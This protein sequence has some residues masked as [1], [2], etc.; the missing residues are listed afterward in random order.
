MLDLFPDLR[1]RSQQ[2]LVAGK[3]LALAD[4]LPGRGGA[5]GGGG[6][7]GGVDTER[8]GP[9]EPEE[10]EASSGRGSLSRAQRRKQKKQQQRAG[11]PPP[12][13]PPR[14][15]VSAASA[16]SGVVGGGG[17]GGGSGPK[18]AEVSAPYNVQ[19]VSHVD[20]N[21]LWTGN[22]EE[23]FEVARSAAVAVACRALVDTSARLA[24][25]FST[26]A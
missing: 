20:S 13:T 6:G 2:Q 8:A 18:V 7:S 25:A 19:R 15:S 11:Q 23:E 14:T 16:S 12:A 21:F 22:L 5:G 17:G 10:S 9:E 4:V 24:P 1:S 26:S 3:A